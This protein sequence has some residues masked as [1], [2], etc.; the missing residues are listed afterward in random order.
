[1]RMARPSH[2]P[3][4]VC[5]WNNKCKKRCAR[6]EERLTAA[7]GIGISNAKKT[8]RTPGKGLRCAV[9][10]AHDWQG[11]HWQ[12]KDEVVVPVRSRNRP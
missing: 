1:M 3:S 7:H 9:D 8:R 11:T 10:D 6:E 12:Q 5:A 2:C 4:K